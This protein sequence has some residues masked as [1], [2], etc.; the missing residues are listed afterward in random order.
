LWWCMQVDNQ[1]Y[2]SPN[3][4]NF[5]LTSYDVTSGILS[6]YINGQLSYQANPQKIPQFNS[7][8]LYI[9]ADP[10]VGRYFTGTIDD[11]RIYNRALKID[12]INYLSK[13]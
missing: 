6:T 13:H 10:S 1:I 12:E 8:D 9:G 2:A 3:N 11:V 7:N 4:W 5:I